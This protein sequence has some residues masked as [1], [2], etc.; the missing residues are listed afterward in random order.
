MNEFLVEDFLTLWDKHS[1][2]G[3]KGIVSRMSPANRPKFETW[4]R[5]S[6]HEDMSPNVLLETLPTAKEDY[7]LCRYMIVS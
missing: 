7:V 4:V 5:K 2:L 6:G 3:I 1:Q